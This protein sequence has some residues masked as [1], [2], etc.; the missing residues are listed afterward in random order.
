MFGVFIPSTPV[1]VLASLGDDYFEDFEGSAFSTWTATGLWHVEDYNYSSDPMG[2]LPSDTKYA[3]YGNA[4]TENYETYENGT[5]TQNWGELISDQLDLTVFGGQTFL[6]FWSWAETESGTTYD[7]KDISIS[8]DGGNTWSYL[9]NVITDGEPSWQLMYFDITPYINSSNA[10]IKFSFDTVDSAVNDGRGWCLDD[11]EITMDFEPP[12]YFE[13]WIDQDYNARVN[14]KRLMTFHVMSYFN[15]TMPNVTIGVAMLGPGVNSSLYYNENVYI[16]SYGYWN[17]TLDYTFLLPGHYDVY[18]YIIDDIGGIWEEWCYWEVEE[19]H[20]YLWINQNNFGTVGIASWMYF[21]AE[22]YF[23][24]GMNATVRM[25]MI[26]PSTTTVLYYNSSVFIQSGAIWSIGLSYIFPESGHYDVNFLLIDDIGQEWGTSCWYE[27]FDDQDFLWLQ[28]YQD[29][30]AEVGENRYMDFGVYSNFSS[31]LYDVEVFV[32]I[33]TPSMGNYTLFWNNSVTLYPQSYW[34]I[35]TSYTFTEMGNYYVHFYVKLPTGERWSEV[36]WWEISEKP[37]E[38]VEMWIEQET[39]AMVDQEVF[40]GFHVITHYLDPILVNIEIAIEKDGYLVFNDELHDVNLEPDVEWFYELYLIFKDPGYYD[41]YFYM[42]DAFDHTMNWE[43]YCWWNVHG[44][45]LRLF[46]DF[47]NE[48]YIHE[49][50]NFGLSVTNYQ[51]YS[52]D[53]SVYAYVQNTQGVNVSVF[54]DFIYDL[55]PGDMWKTDFTHTFNESGQ[56]KLYMIVTLDGMQFYADIEFD[57]KVEPPATTTNDGEDTTTLPT[58]SPG[59]EFLLL[60][61]MILTIGYLRKRQ[62]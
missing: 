34:W 11:I 57:V 58:I 25:E 53:F 19:E 60:P 3:W 49:P 54:S 22:S 8:V 7:H 51:N 29:N 52:V 55:Y 6:T 20:F 42:E 18:F 24:H 33:A 41:V 28:I 37:I 39:I 9:G 17:I 45:G 16:S 12:Q 10:Y 32:E 48:V 31:T 36:C 47:D 56:Y 26:G 62:K 43:R 23:G 2:G 27:V 44:E 30:Y 13:L 38:D 14:E 15:H 40:M 59:F 1:P 50:E 21:Y 35:S 61:L 46:I 4:S 5:E